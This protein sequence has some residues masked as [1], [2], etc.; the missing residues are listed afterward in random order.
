MQPKMMKLI[1]VS[2]TGLTSILLAVK[3]QLNLESHQVQWF[4]I[5]LPGLVLRKPFTQHSVA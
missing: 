1:T 2:V 5:L 4:A 3:E